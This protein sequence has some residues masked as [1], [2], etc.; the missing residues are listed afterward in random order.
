MN[1]IDGS[2]LQL[3]HFIIRASADPIL[4][5]D[6]VLVAEK[7][8]L[9]DLDSGGF[10]ESPVDCTLVGRRL[11]GAACCSHCQSE[12]STSQGTGR[13]SER[14]NDPGAGPRSFPRLYYGGL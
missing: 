7:N 9:R 8:V 10:R 2:H 5:H 6:Y 3:S 13:S 12:R 4:V 14:V 1:D 11:A